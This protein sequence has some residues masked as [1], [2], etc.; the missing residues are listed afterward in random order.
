[1]RCHFPLQ[2]I[3]LIQGSNPHLLTL[4]HWQAGSFPLSPPRSPKYLYNSGFL[5]CNRKSLCPVGTDTISLQV[6]TVG[7]ALPTVFQ[8]FSP[9]F[10][11]LSLPYAQADDQSKPRGHPSAELGVSGHSPALPSLALLTSALCPPHW[12]SLALS[13]SPRLAVWCGNCPE[14]VKRAT[15]D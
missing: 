10:C 15:W 13:G 6:W 14:A 4:L 5:P 12:G 1:M 11:C 8:Y 3:F 7:G 9:I 2:G